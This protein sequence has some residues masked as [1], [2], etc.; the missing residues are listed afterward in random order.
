MGLPWVLVGFGVKWCLL[1]PRPSIVGIVEADWVE[2][3]P[4][5]S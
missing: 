1:S 3:V 4:L 5:S 2:A